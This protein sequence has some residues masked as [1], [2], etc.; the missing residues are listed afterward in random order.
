MASSEF[1]S[2]SVKCAEDVAD[3]S[4]SHRWRILHSKPKRRHS[5]QVVSGPTI[6]KRQASF[7]HGRVDPAAGAGASSSGTNTSDL[8]THHKGRRQSISESLQSFTK[9]MSR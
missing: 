6:L 4:Q 3:V 9:S 5:I 8:N 7:P 2:D 1:R